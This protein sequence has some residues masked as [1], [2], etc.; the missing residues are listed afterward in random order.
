MKYVPS[1]RKFWLLAAGLVIA[2]AAPPLMPTFYVHIVILMIIFAVF[3]MS[4]DI[5]MGYAGLPSLGHAA[6]Y[7]FAAYVAGL[8]CTRYGGTWWQGAGLA[9]VGSS[10]LAA[11]F[12]FAALRARGLYFLLITL[13]L[14]Q[15]LWGA[16]NRWGSLTGG[17]NGLR[18][19]PEYLQVFGTT[20]SA[21]Y[22]AL[23]VLLVLTAVMYQLVRSPFGL[24]L[25]GLRDSETRMRAL[26][27]NVW[28][29]KYIAFVLSALFA[30]AAGVM[31]AY[32]KGFVS[33]FDLSI[34]VSADAILMVILGG[35]G[36][37]FGA[38]IG[39]AVIVGLRNFLSV[40]MNHWLIVLG[41]VFI[42]TVFIAPH[43]VIRWFVQKRDRHE[44]VPVTESAPG[45]AGEFFPSAEIAQ[46]ESAASRLTNAAL[47]R[48]PDDAAIMPSAS[49]EPD[50]RLEDISKSFGGMLAVDA[51]SLTVDAG[52]RVAILGPNGAGKTSLFHLVSGTLKPSAGRIYLF[53]RDVSNM[54]PERRVRLGLGR[55]FQ[56]TNLFRSLTVIS[57]IRLAIFA[58]TGRK[59][60]LHRA[61]DDI[62]EVNR[63]AHTLLSGIGLWHVRDIEVQRLSYGHQ[64]QLEVVMALALRPMIL[65]LDEPT[66]GLSASESAQ[67]VA[68]IRRL[69]KVITLLIIEHDMDVALKV[70]DR[71]VVFHHGQKVADGSTL[72]IRANNKVRE[73]YLGRRETL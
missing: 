39:A 47:E 18:G 22:T 37:L 2:V 65:L 11:L 6:F 54:S 57:N 32:Y 33:P 27:Y 55:T 24:S 56:I 62:D 60:V 17:Y 58:R 10:L 16:A 14:G 67:V 44:S 48:L 42:L 52:Q 66:A 64:R 38:V 8:L 70:A 13:A 3:A 20:L 40:F 68:L 30:A 34:V 45:P 5:L 53:G 71:V 61:A 28:L 4:L 23:V 7:G 29:H 51:V 36:T 9:L 21:Y 43:G 46:I 19:I 59:F 73:I 50:L 31:S 49:T 69:D 35:T 15:V 63:E 41:L 26:G 12:G 72:E 25:E 1:S